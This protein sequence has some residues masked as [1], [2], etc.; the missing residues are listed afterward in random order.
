MSVV[1][2]VFGG[3]GG[4]SGFWSSLGDMGLGTNWLTGSV[5]NSNQARLQG[6]QA[7]AE[8]ASQLDLL[9]KAVQATNRV[10]DIGAPTQQEISLLNNQYDSSNKMLAY[11][12]AAIDRDTA[13][14]QAINPAFVEAGQQAYQLLQ[15]K[16]APV[17]DP[18]TQQRSLQRQGL[19][20]QLNSQMGPG[21]ATSSAG[22]MALNNF[23]LQTSGLM[24]NAQQSYAGTLLGAAGQGAQLSMNDLF[25]SSNASNSSAAGTIGNQTS[26]QKMQMVGP[27]DYINA[28]NM[29]NPTAYAGAQYVQGIKRFQSDAAT[30]QANEQANNERQTAVISSI[31]SLAKMG[32]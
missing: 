24:A 7:Q 20:S 15:G 17:L 18:I 32:A 29:F 4:D 5:A 22:Q 19:M 27:E 14:L 26:M 31:G 23:D 13:N 3:D 10:G 1:D 21:A 28:L 6:L 16:N 2:S 11:H 9:M 12:Q 30:A 8:Q 25:G